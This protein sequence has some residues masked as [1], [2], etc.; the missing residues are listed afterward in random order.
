MERVSNRHTPDVC[1]EPHIW[2]LFHLSV[3]ASAAMT[4]AAGVRFATMRWRGVGWLAMRR[5]LGRSNIGCAGV[6]SR[7]MRTTCRRFS[8]GSAIASG[9]YYR[10]AVR[11]Y[12][13]GRVTTSTGISS[14]TTAGE[15]MAAP[16]VLIAPAR[17]WT[18]AQEDAVI[19]IARPVKA[20]GRA[21]VWRIV[22]VAV[23]TDGL[24][25]YAD[26]NLRVSLWRESQG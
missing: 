15:A 22:V 20:I 7:G 19:E 17:P 24:N 3:T 6:D 5:S 26:E 12:L 2:Q 21:S 13:I 1:S 25:T 18:H 10:C 23:G 16:T 8:L 9:V 11:V 4:A 14:S